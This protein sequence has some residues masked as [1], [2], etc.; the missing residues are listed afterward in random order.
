MIVELCIDFRRLNEATIKDAYPLHCLDEHWICSPEQP[1]IKPWTW[2]E[3]WQVAMSD[4]SREK[5]SF[6]TLLAKY[7]WFVTQLG[8]CKTPM[9][10][11]RLMEE[12]AH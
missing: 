9:T 6:C 1:N 2:P 11:E 4:D 3:T 7:E 12:G 10:L 5:T 8:L